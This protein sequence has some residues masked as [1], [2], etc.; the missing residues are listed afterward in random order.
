MQAKHHNLEK[1]NSTRLNW[2]LVVEVLN[3]RRRLILVDAEQVS[4]HK[5]S[6]LT[7]G[8]AIST[9]ACFAHNG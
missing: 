1:Y 6:F 4:G 3:T 9:L 7:N 8:A 2:C 5:Q